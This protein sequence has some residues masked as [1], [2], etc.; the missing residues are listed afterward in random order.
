MANKIYVGDAAID[1]IY[2]G[3]TTAKV[4]IGD[5]LVQDAEDNPSPG[6]GIELTS[7]GQ[8]VSIASGTSISYMNYSTGETQ[9]ISLPN[10]ISIPNLLEPSSGTF[11][12]LGNYVYDPPSLKSTN[13]GSVLSPY[14]S[15]GNGTYMQATAIA[16]AAGINIDYQAGYG[17]VATWTQSSNKA[18]YYPGNSQVKIQGGSSMPAGTHTIGFVPY[19][20][21]MTNLVV[22]QTYS[23]SAYVYPVISSSGQSFGTDYT[24]V[25]YDMT[26]GEVLAQ[27]SV[28]KI[29]STNVYIFFEDFVPTA[30]TQEF[31]IALFGSYTRSSGS[32]TGTLSCHLNAGS[33]Y[34]R[35]IVRTIDVVYHYNEEF[36]LNYDAFSFD[37]EPVSM[38]IMSSSEEF[39]NSLGVQFKVNEEKY[40]YDATLIA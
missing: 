15:S 21:K 4:Y 14:N 39:G 37:G 20:W 22:G 27:K 17:N 38:R 19:G 34:S 18:S 9:S 7:D 8:G 25:A 3:N 24:M 35:V 23:I 1:K 5:E 33:S 6:G 11:G 32:G 29:S 12:A 40:V 10:S 31:C 16:T 13:Y 36:Y 28:G 26:N 30:S 2:I